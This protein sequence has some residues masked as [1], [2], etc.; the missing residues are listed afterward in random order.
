MSVT[1]FSLAADLPATQL[2]QL[3]W[4]FLRDLD[5]IGIRAQPAEVPAQPGERGLV[6]A[7][8][9]FVIDAIFSSKAADALV[10]LIKAY[11]VRE[12]TM[13]FSVTKPDGTKIDIT[14]KN[15]NSAEVAA[16]LAVAKTAT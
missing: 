11:L 10:D 16:F 14:S 7:I 1:V 5:R 3:T 15:V 2:D 8:G 4:D 6:T 12:E 9:K 13:T